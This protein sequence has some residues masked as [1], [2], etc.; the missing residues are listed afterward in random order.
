[1]Y[2]RAENGGCVHG[3]DPMTKILARIHRI[4]GAQVPFGGTDSPEV[5]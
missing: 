2:A 3:S 4:F 5:S 1:V